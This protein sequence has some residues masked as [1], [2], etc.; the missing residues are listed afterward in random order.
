[1]SNQIRNPKYKLGDVVY[2]VAGGPAMAINEVIIGDR[3]TGT[4]WCQWFSGRKQ[5]RARFPE[6]SLTQTNPKS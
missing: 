2:L 5:E 3:F 6:E 4:Y 1:M